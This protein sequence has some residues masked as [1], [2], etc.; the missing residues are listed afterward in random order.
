MT[1]AVGERRKW[2]PRRSSRWCWSVTRA[3]GSPSSPHLW[4]VPTGGIWNKWRRTRT[5]QGL[6]TSRWSVTDLPH[7]RIARSS[8]F[9]KGTSCRR[10]R[11]SARC[12]SQRRNACFVFLTTSPAKKGSMPFKGF[13]TSWASYYTG[14]QEQARRASSRPSQ[15]TRDGTLFLCHSP[16]FTQIKSSWTLCSTNS[17]TSKRRRRMPTMET[18]KRARTTS[19][20]LTKSFSSLKTWTL[21]PKLSMHVPSNLHCLVVSR[22]QWSASTHTM[23]LQ[24]GQMALRS[25]RT[26]RR[27]QPPL[28]KSLWSNKKC[29][30]NFSNPKMQLS[31][32]ERRH[33]RVRQVRKVMGLKRRKRASGSL[34]RTN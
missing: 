22:R 28:Q 15:R 16:E 30:Y 3:S 1:V 5:S 29:C 31:P 21:P 11:R 34:I 32:M 4:T 23:A 2:P 27:Q 14:P 13:R 18:M 6:C 12:F 33:P 7:W 26:E 17:S 8:A 24:K 10:I 19:L 20:R 25:Q 9:T